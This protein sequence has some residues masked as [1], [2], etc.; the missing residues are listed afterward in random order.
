M[1]YYYSFDLDRLVDIQQI[2][3]DKYCDKFKS[4]KPSAFMM[5]WNEENFPILYTELSKIIKLPIGRARF[6]VTP[7]HQSLDVHAD[8]RVLT[9]N[10]FAINIPIRCR[11]S[12]HYQLWYKYDGE[13]KKLENNPKYANFSLPQD[14]SRLV[15]VDRAVITKPTIVQIGIF[16]GV[17]NHTD[18]HRVVLSLRFD[19]TLLGQQITSLDEIIDEYRVLDHP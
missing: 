11:E 19:R 9:E 1:K 10:I 17:E 5:D 12:N 4:I 3:Y 15:E 7:P 16:H 14:V 6:F 2:I 13:I 18:E 8:G